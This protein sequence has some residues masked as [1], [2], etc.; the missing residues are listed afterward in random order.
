MNILASFKVPLGQENKVTVTPFSIQLD[1]LFRLPFFVMGRYQQLFFGTLYQQQNIFRRYLHMLFSSIIPETYSTITLNDLMH[2]LRTEVILFNEKQLYG[3]DEY[4][5]KAEV[6]NEETRN[7]EFC[8]LRSLA[9]I[10]NLEM[11]VYNFK[12]ITYYHFE[13]FEITRYVP[14]FI[15]Y[16]VLPTTK[17]SA[18]ELCG[19]NFEVYLDHFRTIIK[20]MYGRPFFQHW[21]STLPK[22]KFI[23]SQEF[24]DRKTKSIMSTVPANKRNASLFNA[25]YYDSYNL[26]TPSSNYLKFYTF[27]LESMMPMDIN[28]FI[29][30]DGEYLLNHAEYNNIK[31]MHPSK[32]SAEGQSLLVLNVS[33]LFKHVNKLIVIA[34]LLEELAIPN[35]QYTSLFQR[36]LLGLEQYTRSERFFFI[37]C[38]INLRF[39]FSSVV[40][41]SSE[42]S[43][44]EI[45]N[46]IPIPTPIKNLD[47]LFAFL[48]DEQ[49]NATMTPFLSIVESKLWIGFYADKKVHVREITFKGGA[50]DA[51]K[52]RVGGFKGL[53]KKRQEHSFHY[54]SDTP[55]QPEAVIINVEPPLQTLTLYKD[56]Q[57]DVVGTETKIIELLKDISYPYEKL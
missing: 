44:M 19:R 30:T 38:I 50:R 29:F 42:V 33:R 3:T 7:F 9:E 57:I 56:D 16:D 14:Y 20:L 47:S 8:T 10:I 37:S 53:L 5:L 54:K 55:Q 23:Q 43:E 48:Y 52:R 41:E 13:H 49:N 1:E 39:D 4:F 15:L 46:E 36:V 51:L 11:G 45:E 26:I 6:M 22:T 35:D 25:R 24:A 12:P 40:E 28:V 34:V 21:Y 27:L 31:M 17:K 18:M 2:Y 32:K